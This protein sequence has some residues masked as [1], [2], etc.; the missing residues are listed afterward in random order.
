[1]FRF[2]MI[3]M[4]RP[5]QVPH[6]FY[7]YRREESTDGKGQI[8]FGTKAKVGETRCIMAEARPDEIQKYAQVG[9]KVT[10]R[11]IQRG[12]A[13]AKEHDSLVLVK[14]GNQTRM[15]RVQAVH[16][17][18]ELDIDTAYYCEERSDLS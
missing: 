7:V 15:F 6:L 12:V 1:M 2:G 11:I 14:G 4:M 3:G 17:K 8:T 18:G 13:T 16:N 5:E 9:V 10:H